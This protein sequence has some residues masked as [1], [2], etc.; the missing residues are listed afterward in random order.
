MGKAQSGKD[1]LHFG[2]LLSLDWDYRVFFQD[3]PS[4]IEEQAE[5]EGTIQYASCLVR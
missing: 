3:C 1:S 5:N 4:Q 2:V